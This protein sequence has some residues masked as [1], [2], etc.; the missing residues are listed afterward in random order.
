MGSTGEHLNVV[1]FCTFVFYIRIR[2]V[3]HPDQLDLDPGRQ[4]LSPKKGKLRNSM[5]EKFRGFYTQ[6]SL[7]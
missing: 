5:F 3:L 2:S 1:Q 7:S 6:F 4:K